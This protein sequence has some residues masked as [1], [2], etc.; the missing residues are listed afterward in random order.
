[1]KFNGKRI[2]AKSAVGPL[3]VGILAVVSFGCGESG[4]G[5]T[6]DAESTS[7][8]GVA[9][10][11]AL[12][13]FDPAAAPG[14]PLTEDSITGQVVEMG[15]GGLTGECGRHGKLASAWWARIDDGAGAVRVACVDSPDVVAN[16]EVG[17]TVTATERVGFAEFSDGS[18]DLT[19][20][21]DG[22]LVLYAIDA[23][24]VKLEPPAGIAYES[25]D[26]V[27]HSEGD[28][29]STSMFE[30][31][32][33]AG[34]DEATLAPGSAGALGPYSVLVGWN[35]VLSGNGGCDSPS[36]GIGMWIGRK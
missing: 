13:L 11:V 34:S 36:S 29:C 15:V 26:E 18:N 35:S 7:C 20:T 31:E 16:L 9:V 17:Q 19:I 5:A 14:E 4:G 33:T 22:D 32:I 21:R 27:C 12:A 3:L 2:Q 8:Q 30:L 1:M 24:G 23:A 10:A 6:E 25:G 28:P